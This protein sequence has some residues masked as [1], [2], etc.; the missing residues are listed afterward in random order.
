MTHKIKSLT[1]SASL[2]DLRFAIA[3]KTRSTY[4]KL[5]NQVKIGKTLTSSNFISIN[6]FI[7]FAT[8]ESSASHDLTA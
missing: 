3:F 4:F 6:L 7:L 8:K 5:A 1:F 2:P